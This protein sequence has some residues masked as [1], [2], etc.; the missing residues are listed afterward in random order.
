MRYVSLIVLCLVAMAAL[1]QSSTTRIGVVDDYNITAY[2][3]YGAVAVQHDTNPLAHPGMLRVDAA[4]AVTAVCWG[5]TLAQAITLNLVAG[6][7][8]PCVVT[9]LLDTGTAAITIHVFY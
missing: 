6:E 1:S 4:G 7:F 5:N 2:P 3:L 8:F 9:Y